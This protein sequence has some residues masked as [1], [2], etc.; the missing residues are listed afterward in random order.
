MLSSFIVFVR[1]ERDTFRKRKSTDRN[2]W[3][4]IVTHFVMRFANVSSI[5]FFRNS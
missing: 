1:T 3:D 4:H 5:T 2:L